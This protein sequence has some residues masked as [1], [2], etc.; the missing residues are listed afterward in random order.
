M[1]TAFPLAKIGGIILSQS[2]K[3]MV[4][5]MKRRAA[6]NKYFR[7]RICTPMGMFYNNHFRKTICEVTGSEKVGTITPE[8]A[9]LLGVEIYG[10]FIVFVSATALCIYQYLKQRRLRLDKEDAQAMEIST[11]TTNVA[12]MEKHLDDHERGQ[13]QKI[14]ALHT[15]INELKRL[16]KIKGIC[17]E[18]CGFSHG[19]QETE[20]TSDK[21]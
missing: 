10:E 21:T 20:S 19:S 17:L 4:D 1:A 7:E 15:E 18:E 9:V 6:N 12:N 5:Y 2:A 16:L 3:P 14:S 8:Q 11:A 13:D